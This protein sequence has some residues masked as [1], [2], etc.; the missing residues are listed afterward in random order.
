MENEQNKQNFPKRELMPKDGFNSSRFENQ[1][2]R[3][4]D[5][6]KKRENINKSEIRRGIQKLSDKHLGMLITMQNNSEVS[7]EVEKEL[8]KRHN[9]KVIFEL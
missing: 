9:G 5:F 6:P 8:R 4:G 2:V 1:N 7:K 3:K